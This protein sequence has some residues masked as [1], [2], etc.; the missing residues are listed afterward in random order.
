VHV[1]ETPDDTHGDFLYARD[2]GGGTTTYLD[3]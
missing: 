1:E 3:A 2:G